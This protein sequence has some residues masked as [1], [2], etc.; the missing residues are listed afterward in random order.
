M[1]PFKKLDK[2]LPM[3]RFKAYLATAVQHPITAASYL[4]AVRA[5]VHAVPDYG[6]PEAIAEYADRLPFAKR[7]RLLS[8]WRQFVLFSQTLGKKLPPLTSLDPTPLAHRGRGGMPKGI[9]CHVGLAV[10]EVY[11]WLHEQNLDAGVIPGLRWR[12]KN[13]EGCWLLHTSSK[14]QL[15]ATK[16]ATRALDIIRELWSDTS[17]ERALVLPAYRGRPWADTSLVK[18]YQMLAAAR[19]LREVEHPEY[20]SYLQRVTNSPHVVPAPGRAGK[21]FQVDVAKLD[22]KTRAELGLPADGKPKHIPVPAPE[23]IDMDPGI[24]MA[25]KVD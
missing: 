21:K 15:V 25:I 3:T 24:P 5:A 7:K 22:P 14:E 8:G 19:R 2:R 13:P 17:E 16:T 23:L 11:E 10:L 20:V 9:D 1:A 18:V 12:F 4:A 6:D